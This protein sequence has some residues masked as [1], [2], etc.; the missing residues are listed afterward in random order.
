MDLVLCTDALL[1][2]GSV[3]A[4]PALEAQDPEFAE[5]ASL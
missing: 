1:D 2:L 5:R 4:S 3:R